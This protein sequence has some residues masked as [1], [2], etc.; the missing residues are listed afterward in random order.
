[1]G[2]Y[3]GTDGF[4]GEANIQLTV[5]HAFKV[6]R[7]VGWYY[8]RD[9]KAKIVIGKDTRRSGYMIENALVELTVFKAQRITVNDFF[10][11][12]INGVAEKDNMT[13]GVKWCSMYSPKNGKSGCCKHVGSLYDKGE[14]VTFYY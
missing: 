14:A 4:R 9:H 7:Y 1:M 13:C 10:L 3:F 5:D 6:G 2:K 11:C 12:K 8:G